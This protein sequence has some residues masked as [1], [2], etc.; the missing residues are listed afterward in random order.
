MRI[1]NIEHQG[2]SSGELL[3][4][5]CV[6]LGMAELGMAELGMAVLGF[7]SAVAAK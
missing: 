6:L 4:R 7:E 1:T 5:V 3:D 2:A